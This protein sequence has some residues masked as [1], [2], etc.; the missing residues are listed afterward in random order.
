MYNNKYFN[1]LVVHAVI[2]V[3]LLSR[4]I[5]VSLY[6][7]LSETDKTENG[8]VTVAIT[9]LALF[10]YWFIAC[11]STLLCRK[12]HLWNQFVLKGGS[13]PSTTS[14]IFCTEHCALEVQ[15]RYVFR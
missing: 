14:S 8:V 13:S 11:R 3:C 1:R 12:S 2:E 7:N 4:R 6:H 15:R 9:A 5:D 10:S